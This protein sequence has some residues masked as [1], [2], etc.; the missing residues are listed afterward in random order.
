MLMDFIRKHFSNN[1][2]EK[3]QRKKQGND[4]TYLKLFFSSNIMHDDIA[5]NKYQIQPHAMK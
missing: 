1:P 2:D 5:N 4:K 3:T